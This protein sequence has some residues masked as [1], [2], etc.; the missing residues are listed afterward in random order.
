MSKT[1]NVRLEPA[2]LHRRSRR[3]DLDRLAAA[4][5]E[6][7]SFLSSSLR[8]ANLSETN[9]RAAEFTE[10]EL[11]DV[12]F[13]DV[14]NWREIKTLS[15]SNVDG[16]KDTPTEFVRWALDTMG[17]TDTP[18]PAEQWVKKR[19]SI[20]IEIMMQNPKIK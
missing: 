19:Q 7:T 10:S 1:D 16:M 12:N 3:H 6:G 15:N 4:S 17:A 2:S 11:Q 9:V 13:K 8:S 5:L 18:T 20:R 14:H